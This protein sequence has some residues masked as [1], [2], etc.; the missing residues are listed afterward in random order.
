MSQIGIN[1]PE[2]ATIKLE[3]GK[4]WQEKR[5]KVWYITTE[6]H[7]SSSFNACCAGC[8]LSNIFVRPTSYGVMALHKLPI[9]E[10]RG[11]GLLE[12]NVR[13]REGSV[14]AWRYILLKETCPYRE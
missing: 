1:N 11:T 4:Q 6:Q 12:V 2:T 8:D 9:A 13:E 10:I 3:V 7:V 5:K 14:S